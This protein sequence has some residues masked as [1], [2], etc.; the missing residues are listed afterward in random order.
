MLHTQSC[1]ASM[2]SLGIAILVGVIGLP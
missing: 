2:V 1:D